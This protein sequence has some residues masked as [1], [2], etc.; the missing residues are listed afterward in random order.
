[1]KF[2]VLD[3]PENLKAGRGI[4]QASTFGQEATLYKR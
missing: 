3:L 4:L 2:N 1:V